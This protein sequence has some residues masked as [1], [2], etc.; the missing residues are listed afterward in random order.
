VRTPTG[1]LLRSTKQKDGE[2]GLEWGFDLG[3][4]PIGVDEDGDVL[5]SC[6]VQEAAVP[7]ALKGGAGANKNGGVWAARVLEVLGEMALVQT[8]GIEKK[9]VI[10]EVLRRSPEGTDNKRSASRALT[11]LL[12]DEDGEYVFEDGCISLIE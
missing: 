9:A 8:T 6:V 2:D 12:A 5:T 11:K 1:R 3:V 10:E 7:V 4:L